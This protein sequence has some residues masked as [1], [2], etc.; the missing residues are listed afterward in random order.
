M[1]SLLSWYT[2]YGIIFLL[3]SGSTALWFLGLWPVIVATL[4]TPAGRNAALVAIGGFLLW[5][6]SI[7]LYQK[8]KQAANEALK[9]NSARLEN[10]RKK[11]D[12]ELQSLPPDKL[13]ERGNKWVRN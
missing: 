4:R 11:R 6:A 10:E 9:A 5:A 8:G 12:E 7:F 1:D 2:F 3:I 13:R